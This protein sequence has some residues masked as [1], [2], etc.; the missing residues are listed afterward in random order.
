[1][2]GAE[3]DVENGDVDLALGNQLRCLSGVVRRADHGA[4]GFLENVDQNHRNERLVLEDQH[5][6][7]C[8][9]FR[10]ALFSSGRASSHLKPVLGYSHE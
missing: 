7:A 1:M 5:T 9:R 6:L 10:H 3:V 2:T 4:A 8:Q